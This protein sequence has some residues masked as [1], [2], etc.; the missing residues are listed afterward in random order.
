MSN[1]NGKCNENDDDN[2]RKKAEDEPTFLL[3]RQR[4][5]SENAGSVKLP[6]HF[7][8]LHCKQCGDFERGD[9]L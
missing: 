4:K 1:D 8:G 7:T 2:D 5:E 9:G 3:R 6:L